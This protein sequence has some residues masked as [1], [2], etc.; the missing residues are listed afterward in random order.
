MDDEGF[1]ALVQQAAHRPAH[2]LL[3]QR[4]ADDAAGLDALGHLQP[5]IAGNDRHEGSGHAVGLRA[6]APAE[7]DDVTKTRGGDHAGAGQPPFQHGIGRRGRAV[8]DQVDVAHRKTA[9]AKGGDHAE[10]LV[11]ERRRRLGDANAAVAACV[12]QDEVGESAADIDAGHHVAPGSILI[13]RRKPK[14]LD[15]GYV[16][17]WKGFSLPD[18]DMKII[19]ILIIPAGKGPDGLKPGTGCLLDRFGAA[20]YRLAT[21]TQEAVPQ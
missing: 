15:Y 6:G 2:A 5:E 9:V 17:D 1:A 13:H 3:I 19:C 20:R 10:R 21:L 16:A 4:R 7:L 18:L 11:V 14:S 12:D 8:D